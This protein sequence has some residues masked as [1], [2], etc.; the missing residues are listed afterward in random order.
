MTTHVN[1]FKL[2]VKRVDGKPHV[3]ISMKDGTVVVDTDQLSVVGLERMSAVFQ[4][5]ASMALRDAEYDYVSRHAA[6]HSIKG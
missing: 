2:D 4:A 1:G 6:R 5:A 3:H